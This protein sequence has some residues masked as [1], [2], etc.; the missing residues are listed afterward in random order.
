MRALLF[1]FIA[2]ALSACGGGGATVEPPDVVLAGP[3]VEPLPVPNPT[4]TPAPARVCGDIPEPGRDRIR[5]AQ[6][7][8][9]DLGY[10]CGTVDGLAGRRTEGCVKAFQT[11]VGIDPSGLLDPPTREELACAVTGE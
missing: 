9:N 8:L 10:D 4:P 7:S 5:W 2:L 1:A 3:S 11:D 6:R